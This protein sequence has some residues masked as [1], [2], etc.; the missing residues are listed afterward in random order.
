MTNY[1]QVAT[2]SLSFNLNYPTYYLDSMLPVR[3]IGDSTEAFLS[4]DCFF[5][6]TIK[7]GSLSF[8]PS[9]RFLNALIAFFL[10]F[11]ILLFLFVGWAVI[12]KCL[13][14]QRTK[15][16]GFYTRLIMS[17]I[18]SL[19]LVYPSLVKITFSLYNCY[20]LDYGETWM[21]DDLQIRCWKTEHLTWSLIIGI[22]I[23][24]F[25]VIGLPLLAL[26][27]LLQKRPELSQ[28]ITLARY[29]MLYQ[30]LRHEVFYWEFTNT[31]RKICLIS[32]NV[33]VA[34]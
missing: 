5:K 18:V 27:I 13:S 9:M 33:F 32:I 28:E 30:G 12:S 2:L 6:D 11:V 25:W 24:I 8:F 17:M 29:K 23:F 20:E 10:P 22:P 7:N 15:K 34:N 3:Q 31:V 26:R 19:F 1:I 16:D 4:I 14:K 21:I